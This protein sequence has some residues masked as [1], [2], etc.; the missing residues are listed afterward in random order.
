MAN[1]AVLLK[2][3]YDDPPM[4]SK[5][6]SAIFAGRYFRAL[7]AFSP[8]RLRNEAPTTLHCHRLQNPATMRSR[9]SSPLFSFADQTQCPNC[10][11]RRFFYPQANGIFLPLPSAAPALTAY[12]AYHRRHEAI[13][14]NSIRPLP[15]FS[16][17]P[18]FRPTR[19]FI[20]SSNDCSLSC[21]DSYHPP[22]EASKL[23][24]TL[25]LA[26][27]L[28]TPHFPRATT[29]PA[30]Y[31][32]WM[33]NNPSS[34]IVRRANIRR[35][36]RSPAA[37]DFF[38]TATIFRAPLPPADIAKKIGLSNS[39]RVRFFL[40]ILVSHRSAEPLPVLSRP[41]F[42]RIRRPSHGHDRAPKCSGGRLPQLAHRKITRHFLRASSDAN[43]LALRAVRPIHS[44]GRSK[45]S[46]SRSLL[47]QECLQ[48]PHQVPTASNHR[49][50]PDG[51]NLLH[52]LASRHGRCSVE[53]SSLR[54]PSKVSALPQAVLLRWRRN[55]SP[56]V[57]RGNLPNGGLGV[58]NSAG[59]ADINFAN[60]A[61]NRHDHPAANPLAATMSRV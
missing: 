19:I 22:Y 50:G 53:V 10:E 7:T 43:D 5:P 49:N 2:P 45:F 8:R 58:A 36:T 37:D 6:S 1:P 31:H 14:L 35:H 42:T 39:Q 26:Q 29:T 25:V 54:S 33:W 32:W 3:L 13:Q 30:P 40:R 15:L 23:F 59:Q 44:I 61:E 51:A 11:L 41:P 57:P 46:L 28:R 47:R 24:A 12:D 9:C 60:R 17:E 16:S 38:P 18:W 56:I 21:M 34:D 48:R 20:Q 52:S 55:R 4:C 27:S